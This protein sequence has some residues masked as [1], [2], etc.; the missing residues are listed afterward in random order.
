MRAP[1]ATA[2]KHWFDYLPTSGQLIWKQ[3]SGG[4]TK[5]DVAGSIDKRTGYR[6]ISMQGKKFMAHR[7]VWIWHGNKLEAGMDLDHI[8]RDRA[9][10]RI[11]NLRICTRSENCNNQAKVDTARYIR[12]RP[13]CTRRPWIVYYKRHKYVGA[14]Y[15]REAAEQALESYITNNEKPEVRQ[16]S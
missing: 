16:P 9:D 6:R 3:S 4:T 12:H 10:N 15:T 7:L 11:E 8:N 5:G 14:F 1:S 13:E 2:L